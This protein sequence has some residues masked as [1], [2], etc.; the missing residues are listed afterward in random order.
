MPPA[1][2][3]R[4]RTPA[5]PFSRDS[6]TWRSRV[7]LH[8]PRN[9]TKPAVFLVEHGDRRYVVKDQSSQ[10]AWYRRTVGSWLLR[11]EAEAFRRLL[12]VS[13]VPDFAGWVDK[14]AFATVWAEATPLSDPS[15][16][17]PPEAIFRRLSDL[18]DEMHQHGVAHG[19]PHPDNIL[20]SAQRG[21][22]L[23]DFAVAQL[24]GGS[25][26]RRWLY[27]QALLVD[28]RKLAKLKRQYAPGLL[29]ERDRASLE[30]PRLH[31]AIAGMRQALRRRRRRD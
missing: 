16:A 9:W 25:F 23:V 11:R 2:I 3:T 5:A 18:F 8:T 28:R 12:P 29:T 19:D 30:R 1:T 6:A 22:Y 17:R 26:I 31:R 7:L 13:A 4:N 10:P 14:D 15:N 24:E 21:P 27:R 20:I